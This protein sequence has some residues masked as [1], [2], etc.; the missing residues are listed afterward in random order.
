M[1]GA[2]RAPKQRGTGFALTG[3]RYW[4]VRRDVWILVAYGL[5]NLVALL[6]LRP[7]LNADWATSWWPLEGWGNEVYEHEW[8]YSPVLLP[9]AALMVAGG[10]WVLG[11]AHLAAVATLA[12]LG[13]W[14]LWLVAL[15]AFFWVDLLVGNVF[16][17]VAVAAAFAIA[18]S[19]PGA[20]LYLALVVLMPRPIQIPLAV[21]LVWRRSELR[22]PFALIFG[23]HAVGV[24][25]SGLAMPWL[26]S[27]F[28]SL[29]QVSE[30]F[31]LGPGRLFGIWWLVVG[32]P[33][34][35]L[36]V[37]RGSAPVAALAGLVAS[38]YLLPQHLL[39]GVIAA[40]HVLTRGGDL[41]RA[42]G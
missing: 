20:V 10:P 19:R 16:T 27:L 2:S 28:G 14:M 41:Q 38:P 5:V 24:A 3:R 8:R 11:V 7:A 9:V 26:G 42:E 12:R 33:L 39:M 37:W 30:P 23:L 36:M 4:G 25:A 22:I 35:V 13:G 17:F 32:I 18:G 34:A 6:V 40:P 29:S 21:W 31:S 1:E 15:S